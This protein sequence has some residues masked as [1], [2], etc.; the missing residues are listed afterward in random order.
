MNAAGTALAWCAVQVALVGLAAV[1]ACW[2]VARLHQAASGFTVIAGLGVVFCLSAVAASPWP[3]WSFLEERPADNDPSSRSRRNKSPLFGAVA[4]FFQSSAPPINPGETARVATLTAA[5]RS[6][7]TAR[8]GSAMTAERL[9]PKET[10]SLNRATL[11]LRGLPGVFWL[12][13][14]AHPPPW[15]WTA[16]LAVMFSVGLAAGGTR[17]IGAMYAIRSIRRQG[18]LI[19][20]EEL[21][22]LLHALQAQLGSGRPIELFET[23]ALGAPATMGWRRPVILLP[24]EWRLWTEIERRAVLAH[25]IAHVERGDY[26]MWLAARMALVLHFYHP[27]VHWLVARVRLEQEFAADAAAALVVGGPRPYITVLARM[28]LRATRPAHGNVIPAFFATRGALL[29]RIERLRTT[30]ADPSVT[31]CWASKFVAASILMAATL[32]A[33][34]FRSDQNWDSSPEW[35]STPL[36][37]ENGSHSPGQVDAVKGSLGPS[38]VGGGAQATRFPYPVRI[39]DSRPSPFK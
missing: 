1:G 15:R 31:A 7:P 38:W 28:A 9:A 34:G 23:T 17:L 36:A 10:A 32:F 21:S 25:E 20:D 3:R 4:R 14:P 27:A 18:R 5:P 39:A 33:A 30:N 24:I 6:L 22:S 16:S 13:P 37:I 19:Q 2:L 26:L 12:E 35:L 29:R 11:G 8:A